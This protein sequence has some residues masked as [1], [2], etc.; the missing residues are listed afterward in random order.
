MRGAAW[1]ALGAFVLGSAIILLRPPC[2]RVEV[3]RQAIS[4]E[5]AAA[6]RVYKKV[7]NEYPTH[8]EQLIKL[9]GQQELI[10]PEMLSR[11]RTLGAQVF[12]GRQGREMFLI[13]SFEDP[14]AVV[15]KK[16]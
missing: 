13:V 2:N 16:L 4:V 5:L 7:T 6:S 12:F 15:I 8:L 14:P 10:D 1:I 9:P 3:R 11:L